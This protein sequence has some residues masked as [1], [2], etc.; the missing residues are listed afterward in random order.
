MLKPETFEQLL[1]EGVGHQDISSTHGPRIEAMAREARGKAS[2]VARR[3]DTWEHVTRSTFFEHPVGGLKG[4]LLSADFWVPAAVGFS[5]ELR[6]QTYWFAKNHDAPKELITPFT[7][8]GINYFHGWPDEPARIPRHQD[9][10]EEKGYVAVLSV[11]GEDAG[12][13]TLLACKD[14][15]DARN[16]ERVWHG[17]EEIHPRTS[18]TFANFQ[19]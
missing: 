1:E 12:M 13:L 11:E 15:C 17:A 14:L 19:K 18:Y 8:I 10:E 6:D 16:R 3:I 7:N 9:V 5:T 2:L 4:V